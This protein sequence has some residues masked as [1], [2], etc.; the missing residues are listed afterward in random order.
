MFLSPPSF[1]FSPAVWFCRR[2]ELSFYGEC[3]FSRDGDKITLIQWKRTLL[4]KW[5]EAW[6]RAAY[7]GGEIIHIWGKES[8]LA[9]QNT[10][11]F[12]LFRIAII[13]IW[14]ILFQ[15]ETPTITRIMFF[16][17]ITYLLNHFPSCLCYITQ[18]HLAQD[19]V[20]EKCL[21]S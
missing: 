1:S 19:L 21:H 2:A 15:G 18:K 13:Q 12:F 8:Y 7:T 16:N 10:F 14:R 17:F 4:V 9:L 5:E 6:D 20:I 11:F 3:N